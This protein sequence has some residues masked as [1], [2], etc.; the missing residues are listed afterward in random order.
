MFFR[1]KEGGTPLFQVGIHSGDI[2]G[3]NFW[4]ITSPSPSDLLLNQLKEEFKF[5]FQLKEE[6]NIK[7]ENLLSR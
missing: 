7:N 2:P 5:L 3:D 6:L 1:G 4:C